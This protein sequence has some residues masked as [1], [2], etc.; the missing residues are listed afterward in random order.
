MRYGASR[1]LRQLGG[2][3]TIPPDEDGFTGRECPVSDC[4]GYFKIQFGTGLKG[5]GLPCHCPYCGHTDSHNTFWTREQ[6]DY[7]KSVAVKRVAQAI[8]DDL[9]S[10]EFDHRSRGPF[11]IRMS[12]KVTGRPHPIHHYREKKLETEV[13]CDRC[14]LRYA[15]YGVFAF[16]PDCGV[17]NSLQIVRKNL[18]LA[19]KE[20]AL[21][22][23]VEP[24]LA[25]YL[26]SDALENAVSAF[27]AFGRERC[28]IHGL[29]S[30]APAKVNRISFQNLHAARGR[31]QQALGFDLSQPLSPEEW[32]FACRSFQ[33]RHLLAHKMGV[34]DNAYLKATKDSQAVVGRRISIKPDEVTTLIT[35][36]EKVAAALDTHLAGTAQQPHK[37]T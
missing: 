28:R 34:V 18:E 12:L 14:T 11:G 17:H 29:A 13:T 32:D 20:L 8:L 30:S 22:E 24:D 2:R 7:A 25:D 1:H 21:A 10:L 26:V 19:S 33:K 23:A 5:E 27:D 6:I 15:I 4:L 9:K 3:L 37:T 16:C 31:V 35:L 36:L